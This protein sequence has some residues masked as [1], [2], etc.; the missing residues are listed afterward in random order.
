M[1]QLGLV[2]SASVLLSA[3][4]TN[5]LT[6]VPT[7]AQIGELR[8][9]NKGVV[10]VYTSLHADKCQMVRAD[11]AR[12]DEANRYTSI[13]SYS[14]NSSEIPLY[15]D[16][17]KMPAQVA[18]PA[19]RYGIVGLE[20]KNP[21]RRQ[22]FSAQLAGKNNFL[23]RSKNVYERPIA[24]FEVK[25]GEVVD[26]GMLTLS[27]KRAGSFTS[28]VAPIPEPVLQN[29]AAKKPDMAANLVGRAMVT[30]PQP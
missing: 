18:L 13:E 17:S 5:D 14:L 24:T 15:F 23:D 30:T 6:P 21:Y 2:V 12:P 25:P 28:A 9:G 4:V 22:T 7:A 16:H 27:S 1:R 8:A 20:C 10:V 11:I 29:F 3:C 19:G 26:I